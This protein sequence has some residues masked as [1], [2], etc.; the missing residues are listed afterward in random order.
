MSNEDVTHE[1]IRHR[2]ELRRKTRLCP[3]V[4]S[5]RWEDLHPSSDIH[6]RLLF[7]PDLAEHE[8]EASLRKTEGGN[9]ELRFFGD[10]PGEPLELLIGDFY[11]WEF[12]ASPAE[13]LLGDDQVST[14]P[15]EVDWQA[16]FEAMQAA[17]PV[18]ALGGDEPQAVDPNDPPM[19]VTWEYDADASKLVASMPAPKEYVSHG[20]EIAAATFTISGQIRTLVLPF[21]HNEGDCQ[22]ECKLAG[23]SLD[24]PAEVERLAIRPLQ[25]IDLP[26]LDSPTVSRFLA[27]QEDVVALPAESTGEVICVL[28]RHDY[29]IQAAKEAGATWILRLG[30]ASEDQK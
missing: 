19:T 13:L 30:V 5:G 2:L 26:L 28:L 7:G 8:I 12:E 29:Q 20:A 25:E 27:N 23:E 10:L 6:C 18:G 14:T 17:A 15:A 9:I 22:L 4:F 11:F 21:V 1:R 24:P 16:K 3:L